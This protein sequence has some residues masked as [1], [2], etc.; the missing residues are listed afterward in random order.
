MEYIIYQQNK[1]RLDN[2]LGY[3]TGNRHHG[4][5]VFYNAL[6]AAGFHFKFFFTINKEAL[7]LSNFCPFTFPPPLAHFTLLAQITSSLH[8]SWPLA[9]LSTRRKGELEEEEK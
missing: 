7:K 6:I 2:K 9:H 8:S 1:I 4:Y 3:I 5:D